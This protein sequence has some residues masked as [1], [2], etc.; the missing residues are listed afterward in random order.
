MHASPASLLGFGEGVAYRGCLGGRQGLVQRWSGS[1]GDVQPGEVHAE[2]MVLAV[3][4][5]ASRELW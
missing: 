5:K 3:V 1:E 4:S 2:E